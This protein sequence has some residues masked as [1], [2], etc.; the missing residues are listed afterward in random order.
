MQY[1]E[2]RA[3]LTDLTVE[4]NPETYDLCSPHGDRTKPPRGWTID[5]QRSDDV[6]PVADPDTPRSV[7]DTVAL[8][9]AALHDTPAPGSR[10][11]LVAVAEP[12]ADAAP[13]AAPTPEPSAAVSVAPRSVVD[14]DR[15]GGAS[16]RSQPGE[17]PLRRGRPVPAAVARDGD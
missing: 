16:V 6:M 1:A 12:E 5:D 3:V 13:E 17:A 15:G 11:G 14:A 2:Q 10:P 9:A 4:D 7:D 8:L